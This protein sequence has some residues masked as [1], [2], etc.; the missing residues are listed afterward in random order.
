MNFAKKTLPSVFRVLLVVLL[1]S[2]LSLAQAISGV[3]TN[4]TTNKPAGGDDVVLLKLAQGMQEL[5][6]TKTDSKGRF[7]I[8]VPESG[9]HLVRVTHDKA[10]YFHPV[11]PGTQSIEMDVYSAADH[12]EGVTLDADVMRIQTDATG[13]GLKVVEHFFVKNESTPPKT[14]FS[15]H[16]FELYL[17]PGAVVEGSAAKAPGGM[18]VQSGLVPMQDPNHFTLLFPIRPGE[19]E[20]QVS[21][22]LPYKDSLV[23]NPRPAMLTDNLVV[24]LPKS[25]G[26]KPVASAPYIGMPE[27]MGAQTYVARGIQPSQPVGFTL[28]GSGELPRDTAAGQTSGG[29]G[30]AQGAAGEQATTA[31]DNRPGGG[32]AAPNDKDAT[33]ESWISKYRWPLIAALF[34]ALCAG[35]ATMLLRAPAA[36]V[37]PAAGAPAAAPAA[38]PADS[39]QA[40]RDEMFTLETDRLEGRV[41]PQEY[42]ELK[43]AFDLILRRALG[44]TVRVVPE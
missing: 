29:G 32:L 27:E 28:T 3:V 22:K 4:K 26:F 19:T 10:N 9:L 1:G 36:V 18:A 30:G 6:R 33:R 11:Q 37:A 34:L 8:D 20:F 14:L 38:R 15:E 41:T 21:Y 2:G 12:V 42:A 35:A 23:L 39:L 17:P 40:L 13:T 25:M 43:A 44:R 7:T 31:P 16:P 24:M 5:A